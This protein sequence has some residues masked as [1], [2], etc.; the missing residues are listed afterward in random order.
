MNI[1]ANLIFLLLSTSISITSGIKSAKAN[2]S[3]HKHQSHNLMGSHGMVLMHHPK[4]GFYASHMPLYSTP[5]NYQI[6]YQVHIDKPKPIIN[7][8]NNGRVT[9]LPENFDLSRLVNGESFSI[10]T[11]VYQGHFERG[12]KLG[13]TTQI[14]FSTPILVRK[15][16]ASFQTQSATFYY[17]PLSETVAIFAHKIQQK[18]SFDAI[19]FINNI[20]HKLNSTSDELNRYFTCKKPL[21]L[22]Q[23]AITTM[24]NNCGEL[25]GQY[26][27]IKDFK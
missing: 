11:D 4:E 16:S 26:I 2:D 17:L 10:N 15:L 8:I 23:D 1:K 25:N 14:N 12:G 19:G 5:H 21:N 9:L 20:E 3:L 6:I 18:P 27:E 13:L 22:N 7:L 24:L